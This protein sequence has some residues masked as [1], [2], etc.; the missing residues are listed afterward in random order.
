MFFSLKG[1]AVRRL[2]L[3]A[4]MG[5][6]FFLKLFFFRLVLLGSPG[7]KALHGSTSST[8]RSW[9]RIVWDQ[10]LTSSFSHYAA[11]LRPAQEDEVWPSFNSLTSDSGCCGRLILFSSLW[12]PTFPSSVSA[13]SFCSP[14]S[15]PVTVQWL[16]PIRAS[17]FMKHTPLYMAP[18]SSQMKPFCLSVSSP[19]HLKKSFTEKNMINLFLRKC[20]SDSFY[21]CYD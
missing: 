19:P 1:P 18:P 17:L 3:L 16:L 11:S 14:A 12:N 10:M 7:V 6:V 13:S 5:C 21:Y 9:S 15:H 20:L 8:R 2:I 4:S